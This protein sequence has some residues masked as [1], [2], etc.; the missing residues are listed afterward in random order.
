MKQG[1]KGNKQYKKLNKGER[2]NVQESATEC[3]IFSLH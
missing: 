2:E 1:I 3:H